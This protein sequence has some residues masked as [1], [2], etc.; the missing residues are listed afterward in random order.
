[1]QR[2]RQIVDKQIVS[3]NDE[4]KRESMNEKD[5]KKPG[6]EREKEKKRKKTF[7]KTKEESRSERQCSIY[8]VRENIQLLHFVDE[9]F[10]VCLFLLEK[11]CFMEIY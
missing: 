11:V 7:I 6:K 1:M 9:N 3:E 2:V 10:P 5:A 4:E 8:F